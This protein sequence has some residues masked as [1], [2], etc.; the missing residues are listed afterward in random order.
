MIFV[1][2]HFL[3]AKVSLEV[4]LME[5]KLGF[6]DPKKL[7]LSPAQRCPFNRGNKINI[8]IVL[9]M[10]LGTK[11]PLHR[12]YPQKRFHGS[13]IPT[14][15]TWYA[16][17]S[18][19]SI[20]ISCVNLQVRRNQLKLEVHFDCQSLSIKS[21]IQLTQHM[22]ESDSLLSCETPLIIQGLIQTSN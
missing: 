4:K 19:A 3:S 9:N 2:S 20:K 16:C 10:F 8:L 22:M 17:I 5:V 13:S 15:C 7:S 12:S 6:W 11:C 18:T 14:I 21:T 1:V